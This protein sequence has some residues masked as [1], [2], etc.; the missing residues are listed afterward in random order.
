MAGEKSPIS[1]RKSVPPS[2]SSMRPTRL[3][4]APVNAPFSWP[5]SSLSNSPSL[6][7]A[8]LTFTKRLL[9]PQAVVMDGRRHEFLAGARFAAD[10]HRRAGR[11]D[12]VDPQVDL[13]HA[14]RVADDVLRAESLLEGV[15]EPQ[16]LRLQHLPLRFFHAPRLDVVGDHA[17]HDFQEAAALLELLGVVQGHIDRERAHDLAAQGDGHAEKGHVGVGF[18]LPLIKPVGESRLL[19][20]L[21][22]DGRLAGLRRRCR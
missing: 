6:S 14:V 20:D 7:A 17:G 15:A 10:E 2:A 1:S 19:E 12:L 11:G 13:A 21:G 3:N 22:N 8:Q 16:V 4:R 18:R 9:R 5:K